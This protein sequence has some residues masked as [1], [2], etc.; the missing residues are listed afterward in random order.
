M[1]SYWLLFSRA[2]HW[3]S[4][5]LSPWRPDL[6]GSHWLLP[7]MSPWLRA[8]GFLLAVLISVSM[9]TGLRRLPL[10]VAVSVSMVTDTWIPIGCCSRGLPIGCRHVC[11]HGDRTSRA[12]I[13]CCHLCLHGYEHT[14]SF[15]L[16]SFLSPWQRVF[17]GSHWLSP[18]LSPWQRAR[19][20]L[21]AVVLAG[22]HWLSP[23]LSP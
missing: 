9:A 21:L 5:R 11:L 4:P 16:F 3:L 8:H 6:A 1:D 12:P 23:I 17:V 20:F 2:P 14:D 10:A 22:S 7:F 15:W 19:G 13:G 18:F